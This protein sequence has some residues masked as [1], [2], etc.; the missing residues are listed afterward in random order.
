MVYKIFDIKIISI[1]SFFNG[2]DIPL[3]SK[4]G[5]KNYKKKGG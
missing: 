4:N 3:K 5:V 2:T 1:E